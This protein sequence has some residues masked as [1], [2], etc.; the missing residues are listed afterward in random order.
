MRKVEA[1]VINPLL[2]HNLRQIRMKNVGESVNF[3]LSVIIREVMALTL[4]H[5]RAI[6]TKNATERRE[7]RH[8]RKKQESTY[9]NLKQ[10][11]NTSREMRRKALANLTIWGCLG[12]P[13][14]GLARPWNLILASCC[15]G[16]LLYDD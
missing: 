10:L 14:I 1:G 9:R 6:I 12:Q 7:K 4:H 11:G 16:S 2:P 8:F 5:Q 3:A 15:E 13:T